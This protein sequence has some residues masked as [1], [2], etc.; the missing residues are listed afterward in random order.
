MCDVFLRERCC[1][2]LFGSWTQLHRVENNKYF[3]LKL[4]SHCGI[5]KKETSGEKDNIVLALNFFWIL[6]ARNQARVILT[7]YYY[8]LFLC[9]GKSAPQSM[10]IEV[11]GSSHM[12]RKMV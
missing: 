4:H 2:F 3:E 11:E 10:L 6:L 8:P 1:Y 7:P 9:V 12:S 5:F